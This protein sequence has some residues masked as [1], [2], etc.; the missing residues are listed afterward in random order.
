MGEAPTIGHVII[1]CFKC[2]RPRH[3]PVTC[4]SVPVA[5]SRT[6][7]WK[8]THGGEQVGEMHLAFTTL[9]DGHECPTGA[10]APLETLRLIKAAGGNATEGNTT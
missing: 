6:Y 9:P 8:V 1:S 5:G 4:E 10:T 2:G 3:V 7:T